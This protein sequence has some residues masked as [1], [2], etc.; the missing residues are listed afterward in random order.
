MC[1]TLLTE[2]LLGYW[3]EIV[4]EFDPVSWGADG[5]RHVQRNSGSLRRREDSHSEY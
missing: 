1:V 5:A 4:T 2:L 3:K